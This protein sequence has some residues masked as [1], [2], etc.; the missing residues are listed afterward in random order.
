MNNVDEKIFPI[1]TADFLK[2]RVEDKNLN[3]TK[4]NKNIS[5]DQLLMDI[6]TWNH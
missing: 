6:F 3:E 4:L 1:F 5:A 2:K